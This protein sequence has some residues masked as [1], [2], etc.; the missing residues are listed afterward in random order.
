MITPEQAADLSPQDLAFVEGREKL[1]NAE[2]CSSVRG[3]PLRGKGW[4][5]KTEAEIVRRAEAAGWLV[6]RKFAQSD[7][8]YECRLEF[9][10]P[11]EGELNEPG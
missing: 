11:D 5:L 9:R 4:N 6:E 7:D 3:F 10:K 1:I 2:L 8:D